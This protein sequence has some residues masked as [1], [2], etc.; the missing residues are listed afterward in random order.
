MSAGRTETL[1]EVARAREAHLALWRGKRWLPPWRW[2]KS[3]ETARAYRYALLAAAL[4]E[5]S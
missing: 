4:E 3:H 2:L 1:A 5:L